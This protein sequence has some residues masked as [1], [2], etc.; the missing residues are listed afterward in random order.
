MGHSYDLIPIQSIYTVGSSRIRKDLQSSE[1]LRT[2]LRRISYDLACSGRTLAKSSIIHIY[3]HTLRNLVFVS[4][5]RQASPRLQ[6]W[7]EVRHIVK[8]TLNAY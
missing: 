6:L 2:Y 7:R 8:R 5:K 3:L 4:I 1:L